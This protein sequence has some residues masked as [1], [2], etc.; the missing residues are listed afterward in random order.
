MTYPSRLQSCKQKSQ[1]ET[2]FIDFGE[3]EAVPWMWC[4]FFCFA[5]PQTMVML[6]SLW[7]FLTKTVNRP[8]L[9]DFAVVLATETIHVLGLAII[10]FVVLPKLDSV[11][12]SIKEFFQKLK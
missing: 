9:N 4:L 1:N 5:F 7:M 6:Q 11:S 10:H 3:K 2:L 12:I 8:K